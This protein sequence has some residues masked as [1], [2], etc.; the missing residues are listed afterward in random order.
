MKNKYLKLVPNRWLLMVFSLILV[1]QGLK[2]QET[3]SGMV[4]DATGAALPG[5]SIVEKGTA[6]GVQTDFDGNYTITVVGS[7]PILVFSYIGFLKQELPLNGQAS[8]N[9]VLTEDAAKL[10]EVVVVGYGTSK[11][12]DVTGALTSV[13]SED[14]EKQPLN[15]V[16]Q[17]L[18]GRAAGVQVTQT[19]GEPGGGFKIRIRGA[20]SVT[21][22]NEPLYVVDGQ[23]VDISTVNVNDIQSME[24][25]KDAS[26]TAIYGT[27]GA[28]G[29]ILITTKKGRVGKAKINIDLFSG[30]SSVTQKLDLLNA[31]EFAEGVIFAE[32]VNPEEDN[33]FFTTQEIENLKRVGGT[34][35][36]N[37][38][39]QT[40]FFNNV[41]VSASGGSE[42]IDYYISGNLY[43]SGGT[44]IDEKFKR[45]NLRSNLNAQLTKNLKA[46]LNINVGRVENSGVRADLGVGLSFDPTTPPF[47]ENGDYNFNSIKNLAT[48]EINPILAADNNI[49]EN[50][51]DRISIAGYLNY[52]IVKNLVFNTS[53]GI[54]KTQRFNNSYNPLLTS[55]VGIANVDN[56][57]TSDLFNTNRLTYSVDI[58]E[59]SSLKIDAVHELVID[60]FN[61]TD[62][63]ARNFF[64]DLVTYKDLSTAQFQLTSNT[65][66]KRELESFLGRV[67]YSMLDKYL[68]TLSL[69]AKKIIF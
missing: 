32:G 61:R 19:S 27:R 17:A 51:E 29:V 52:D 67:N 40:A 46:G 56:I 48:S 12:S 30:F 57:Y 8:L 6:N 31:G 50:S 24:V 35:W 47:D 28:N 62:I 55:G 44:V 37:L 54:V 65:E 26:S 59:K 7:E 66:S 25:L 2:A 9:V 5:A 14:F 18:Q 34:D 3:V 41:Q 4:T 20:N 49:R 1:C 60:K 22:G 21:G 16:S 53:A 58:G 15:D 11:K 33:P 42:A 68:F 69:R 38:L 64:T 43:E 10:D 36:Q 23:F 39:F 45:L 63:D 13:S